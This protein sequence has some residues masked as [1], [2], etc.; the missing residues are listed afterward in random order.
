MTMVGSTARPGVRPGDVSEEPR[1]WLLIAV[2]VATFV[3]TTQANC[4]ATQ[5]YPVCF[6]SGNRE[7]PS[8]PPSERYDTIEI[9]GGFRKVGLKRLTIQAE[10]FKIIKA[11]EIQIYKLGG[12]TCQPGAFSCVGGELKILRFTWNG[13]QRS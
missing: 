5:S 4:L 2:L 7:V 1:R 8:F 13:M 12:I 9:R 6:I 3:P 10:S 11:N